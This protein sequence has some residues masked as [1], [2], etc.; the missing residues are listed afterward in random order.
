MPDERRR[1]RTRGLILRRRATFLLGLSALLVAAGFVV[2]GRA[3]SLLCATSTT[4]A[5]LKSPG[6]PGR[7]SAGGDWLG[8]DYN[9]SSGAGSLRDFASRGIV[10]DRNGALEVRAGRTIAGSPTLAHGLGISLMAG[11]IPDVYVNPAQGPVG[12]TRDPNGR[13]KLCLPVSAGDIA[14][15]V[16]QFVSTASSIRR[17]YPGR[18]IMFEPMNEPWNWPYPPGTPSGQQAATQYA[19][20]LARLLP[21]ARAAGVPLTDIYVPTTGLL[22]DGTTWIP[23]LYRAQPCL[24][25]GPTT[26]GPIEGWSAHPYG[27]PH[28]ASEGID[29][30]PPERAAMLSGQDNIIVTE[31][32]FCAADVNQG[33][34]CDQNRPDITASSGQ[35]AAWLRETLHE[36]LSMHRAGWLRAL[37]IWNRASGGWAM[38][39]GDG[40]LTAQGRV[41]LQFAAAG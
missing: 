22:A 13:T 20:V 15:Y 16:A 28:R 25:P 18:R 21:A 23:D 37:L 41:F 38:Q 29:A 9:S 2:S 31:I 34:Y 35:T 39:N 5:P 33:L 8:L 1:Q 30:L 36:A 11:M 4:P 3:C 19:A 7:V 17:A 12:C 27:L 40:S 24:Q 10:Y 32:G 26:C 14:A 6:R